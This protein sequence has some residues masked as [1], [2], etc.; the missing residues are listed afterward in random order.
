MRSASGWSGAKLAQ[1]LKEAALIAGRKRYFEEEE[2]HNTIL[3]E[4]MD[5]AVDRLR[6][7]PKRVGM[8]LSEQGPTRRAAVEVGVALTAHLLRRLE[9][10]KVECCDRAS[11]IPRGKVF[12]LY[13]FLI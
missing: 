11:I 8:I 1:L 13:H 3:T 7:G 12:R 5:E 10:A 9:N 2:K 6:I 4:D